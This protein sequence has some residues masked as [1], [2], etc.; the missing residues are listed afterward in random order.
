MDADGLGW[1]WR[2]VRAQG[3]E[4]HRSGSAGSRDGA[5]GTRG[6][7][8]SVPEHIREM[9]E[10]LDERGAIAAT[11]N[12]GEG[13]LRLRCCLLQESKWSFSGGQ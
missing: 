5:H 8:E 1:H 7:S 9:C 4:T 3:E 10:G 12:W 11:C 2:S 6:L 13:R